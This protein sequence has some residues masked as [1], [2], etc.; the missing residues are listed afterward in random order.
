M[1]SLKYDGNAKEKKLQKGEFTEMADTF[2]VA[3]N[4][5]GE[6]KEAWILAMLDHYQEPK[7]MVMGHYSNWSLWR[8]ILEYPDEFGWNGSVW[9][10]LTANV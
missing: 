2:G 1:I 7:S 6:T 4:A 9:A 10:E 8:N 3:G 5:D